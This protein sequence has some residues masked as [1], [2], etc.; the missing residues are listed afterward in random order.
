M[1]PVYCTGLLYQIQ[2]TGTDKIELNSHKTIYQTVK[3]LTQAPTTMLTITRLSNYTDDVNR[4]P[5]YRCL[6]HG[7]GGADDAAGDVCLACYHPPQTTSGTGL[8]TVATSIC[9]TVVF[10]S[11]TAIP[12][13]LRDSFR[14]LLF[15]PAE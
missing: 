12:T 2:L 14:C 1:T 13:L 8:L 10:V 5:V 15:H 4:S 6:T 7:G 11:L 9:L 3:S